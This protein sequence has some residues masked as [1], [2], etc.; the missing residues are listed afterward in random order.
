MIYAS[1]YG[2][3]PGADGME[4][5]R[6]LQRAADGEKRQV[7]A[8]VKCAC[9]A[10]GRKRVFPSVPRVKGFEPV[11]QIIV[12]GQGNEVEPCIYTFAGKLR[13][14]LF[15]GGQNVQK[16]KRGHK[17]HSRARPRR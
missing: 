5:A 11:R 16:N 6:A 13:R 7:R 1:D 3:L 2:F 12:R 4:N 10:G 15:F 17:V 8:A 14:F 9:R